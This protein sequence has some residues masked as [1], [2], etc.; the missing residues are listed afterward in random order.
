MQEEHKQLM[1]FVLISM[2]KVISTILDRFSGGM[3]NDIRNSYQSSGKDSLVARPYGRVIK[4]F[5]ILT[6]SSKMIPHYDDQ[7]DSTG[8]TEKL[9]MFLTYGA[10]VKQYALGVVSGTSR[11]KIF[12]RA[13]LP[14]GAWGA[15]TSGEG[16]SAARNEKVFVAYNNGTSDLI[17]GLS[18]GSGIWQYN[19]TTPAFTEQLI[20]VTYTNTA[21]GLV[22]S[23]DD[24]CYIPYDNK[25]ASKNAAV[26]FN[27]TA[28]TL[29][30][31]SIITSIWESGNYLAIATKPKGVGG[32]SIVYYW[33]RDSTLATIS[34]K[35]DCGS[36]DIAFGE[37]VDG[38][39][40]VMSVFAN[41]SI[42][43]T[44]KVIFSQVFASGLK[45]IAEFNATN[46]TVLFGNN[47]QKQN[48]R[49][50]FMMNVEIDSVVYMGVWSIGKNKNGEFGYSLEY[51][52]NN[53]ATTFTASDSPLGFHLLGDY[54]TVAYKVGSTYTIRMTNATVFSTTS[55]DFQSL[56]F[57]E[58]DSD[59]TKKL[60]GAT[61][62]F[63]PL[64]TT[65][66]TGTPTVVLKYKKEGESSFTQIFSYTTLA[67]ISHGAIN[68]EAT[69]VNLPAYKEIEWEIQSKGNA[70]IT[71]LKWKS[72]ILE[73]KGQF[74]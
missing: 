47:I 24:I 12:E 34:E 61:V 63:E 39:S 5:D 36:N 74:Y 25:I 69:G 66:I 32:K 65:G 26:A 17:F 22:H 27:L 14:Q 15:S 11:P 51:L 48:G 58:G 8:D 18:G 41:T 21:Q 43:K 54:L 29:P 53:G 2:G 64:S 73:G 30:I 68:I 6:A 49:L 31:N 19:I 28:L 71:G 59:V 40:V 57:N 13:S 7:A 42:V 37:D 55:C 60:K 44:P 10:T 38:Y 20:A 3:T 56:I 62:M 70:I 72:E 45:T 46:I 23:K 33:D 16:S 9:C 4:N 50:Y 1:Q 35:V 52:L 67:T